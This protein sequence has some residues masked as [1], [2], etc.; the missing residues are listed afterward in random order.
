MTAT[1]DDSVAF[2]NASGTIRN[3]RI[4]DSF[5]RGILL[6]KSPSAKLDN[7]ILT[8]CVVLKTQLLRHFN[9]PEN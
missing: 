5:G 6:Y 9:T 8:R 2:F 1:G 4:T 3:C 7:N